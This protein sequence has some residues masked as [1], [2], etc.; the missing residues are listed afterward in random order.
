M[1]PYSSGMAWASPGRILERRP[2]DSLVD[3]RLQSAE[4]RAVFAVV[5]AVEPVCS[6]CQPSL[7]PQLNW[8]GTAAWSLS[9]IG[10]VLIHTKP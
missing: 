4:A 6:A 1:Y 5:E 8:R 7:Q 2:K 9:L 3:D 10:G